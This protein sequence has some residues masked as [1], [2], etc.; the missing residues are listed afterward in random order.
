MLHL[1]LQTDEGRINLNVWL[2][3]AVQPINVWTDS[4]S[5]NPPDDGAEWDGVTIGAYC[6]AVLLEVVKCYKNE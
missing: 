6:D 1:L 5:R 3:Q 4:A 2:D